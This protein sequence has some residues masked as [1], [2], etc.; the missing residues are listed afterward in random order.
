MNDIGEKIRALRKKKGLTQEELANAAKVNP[1]TIQRIE[2]NQSEPRGT[3]LNLICE[4]LDSSVED[5]VDYGKQE[6][7][8]YLVIFHLSVM[9]ATN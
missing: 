9:K 1:R 4:V 5:L 6:D 7:K 8:N 2:N 3:T